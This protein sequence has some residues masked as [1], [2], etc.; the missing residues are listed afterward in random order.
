[1]NGKTER[2]AHTRSQTVDAVKGA[3]ILLVMAGHVL[4][5][6]HM[7]DP[8]LYDVIKVIQMPLFIM[9]SG[10][11]CGMGRHV[12]SLSDYGRILKKRALAYLTPFF[13]WILLLHPR[14]P[15]ASV[16]KVLFDLDEGLW[17]LMTLFILTVMVYTA[18]LAQSAVRTRMERRKGAQT[19]GGRTEERYAK[20]AFWITYLLLSAFVVLETFLGWQ[21]LSPGLTRLYLPFYLAGYLAGGH[22]PWLA[23]IPQGVKKLLCA[24]ALILLLLM[25][26]AWDLQDVGTLLLLGRQVLASFTGCIAVVLLLYYLRDGRVKRFLAFLGGYTL[27]IYVL[28]FHFATVL[29]DGRSY[30]LY[31]WEGA[32][33]ALASFA[34]MSLIT[35]A[36]IWVTK[37]FWLLDFLLYGKQRRRN[38]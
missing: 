24:A 29:N 20:A 31:T 35:A 8:Y 10:Y 34:V 16:G 15:L 4:V 27:E 9:V 22:R 37:K 6:N 30:Q 25:A 17:F 1:M 36:I 33:F 38:L 23:R 26:A 14:R 13:F 12:G 18:Q 5:W 3:A 11:L 28:H 32:G 7:E 21:F 19:G 2:G